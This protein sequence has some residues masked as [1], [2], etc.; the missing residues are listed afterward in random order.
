MSSKK[1][2]AKTATGGTAPAVGQADPPEGWRGPGPPPAVPAKPPG[3]LVLH[4][5]AG[6]IPYRKR[7]GFPR[8]RFAAAAAA[9]VREVRHVASIRYSEVRKGMVVIHEG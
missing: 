1:T 2:C 7:A 8:S 9:P 4:G 5:R 3:L 6:Q